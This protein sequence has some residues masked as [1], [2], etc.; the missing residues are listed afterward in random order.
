MVRTN[1]S[2]PRDHVGPLGPFF[3]YVFRKLDC[4]NSSFLN[5][6]KFNELILS[7]IIKT[8]ATRCQILTLKFTKFDLGWGSAQTPLGELTALPRGQRSPEVY[9]NLLLL[10]ILWCIVTVLFQFCLR[11]L[12]QILLLWMLEKVTVAFAL[13]LWYKTLAFWL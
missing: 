1:P 6:T 3:L 2:P 4:H 7:K 10:I 11:C 12:F 13:I 9:L 8:V 5:C